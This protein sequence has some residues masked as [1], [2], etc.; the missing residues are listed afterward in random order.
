MNGKIKRFVF[1]NLE[2]EFSFDKI[3]KLAIESLSRSSNETG[4]VL[5]GYYSKDGAKAFIVSFHKQTVDSKGTRFNFIRGKKGLTELMKKLWKNQEYY[6]G[7][8]HLHPYSSSIAS[9]VDLAQIQE[10]SKEEQYKCPE[11]IL[12]IIGGEKNNFNYS[13]YVVLNQKVNLMKEQ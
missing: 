11:P 6:L 7:E 2:V 4:G 1:E 10:I 13:V 12:V 5:T 9:S 8:W 3:E